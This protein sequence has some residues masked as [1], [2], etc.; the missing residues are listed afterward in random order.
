MELDSLIYTK[1]DL[2]FDV[3]KIN[4]SLEFDCLLLFGV[5]GIKTD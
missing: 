4:S 5:E 1:S 2:G 3:L